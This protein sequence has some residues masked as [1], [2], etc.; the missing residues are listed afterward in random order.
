MPNNLDQ[1]YQ[2]YNNDDASFYS[3]SNDNEI[4]MDDQL[5]R[6]SK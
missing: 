2:M 5:N 6:N 3:N 4:I 1:Q